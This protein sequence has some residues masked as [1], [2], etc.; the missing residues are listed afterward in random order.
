MVRGKLVSLDKDANPLTNINTVLYDVMYFTRTELTTEKHPVTCELLGGRD[1]RA[2][3]VH[4]YVP[5]LVKEL[6]TPYG[7]APSV[8]WAQVAYLGFYIRRGRASC[9]ISPSDENKNVLEP[10]ELWALAELFLLSRPAHTIYIDKR[11]FSL[12]IHI[13]L[14]R[15]YRPHEKHKGIFYKHF[16]PKRVGRARA[17]V[18]RHSTFIDEHGTTFCS[19]LS[20]AIDVRKCVRCRHFKEP[21][22]SGLPEL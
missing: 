7:Q 21:F 18:C 19:R 2:Y 5:V 4:I 9:G 22:A 17:I 8:R 11:Y 6:S 13:L 1:C 14:N 12:P 3:M 16:R 15:G 20:R 10:D